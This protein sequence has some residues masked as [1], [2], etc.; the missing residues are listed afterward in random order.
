MS[1]DNVEI[2]REALAALQRGRGALDFFAPDLIWE[3]ADDEPDAGIYRGHDGL[4]TL[5]RQWLESFDKLTFEP[6]EFID[7]GDKVVMPYRLT[8][9]NRTTDLEFEGT[10]TWVFE[11]ADGKIT[12][13]REYREKADALASVGLTT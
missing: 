4:R 5:V 13:V 2:A 3:T 6:E 9:H 1:A 8:A 11:F 12:A 7:A 10:E